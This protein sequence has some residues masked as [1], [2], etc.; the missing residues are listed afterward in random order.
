[1]VLEKVEVNL[2][3]SKKYLNSDQGKKQRRKLACESQGMI[4]SQISF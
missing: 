4:F 2:Y 3:E 1:M